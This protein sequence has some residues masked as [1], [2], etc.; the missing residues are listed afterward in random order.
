MAAA[1]VVR[2]ATVL[3]YAEK[4]I[5]PYTP[6]QVTLK[7]IPMDLSNIPRL[8]MVNNYFDVFMVYTSR[9]KAEEAVR[10]L[11]ERC[12]ARYTGLLK[13]DDSSEM[14][15]MERYY[16]VEI[17]EGQAFGD[18]LSVYSE[19]IFF[20]GDAAAEV[21]LIKELPNLNDIN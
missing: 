13:D 15:D 5:K 14:P 12:L 9:E 1:S 8:Y 16:V 7:E 2:A 6:C 20:R 10:I 19:C 11:K 18:E 17:L 4:G 21:K 3:Q